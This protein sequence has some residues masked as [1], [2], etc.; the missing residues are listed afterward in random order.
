M[1]FFIAIIAILPAIYAVL[2]QSRQLDLKLRLGWL[3]GFLSALALLTV[4]AFE[5]HDFLILHFKILWHPLPKGLTPNNLSEI[6]VLLLVSF[7]ALRLRYVRLSPGRLNDFARLS[8]NLLWAAKYSELLSLI[9][10]HH[11]QLFKS[12]QNDSLVVKI[13]RQ[14]QLI[15]ANEFSDFDDYFAS[16]RPPKKPLSDKF[17][18]L[19]RMSAQVAKIESLRGPLYKLAHWFS[20]RDQRQRYVRE[21]ID[22]VFLNKSFVTALVQIRPYLGL[23]IIDEWQSNPSDKFTF[24]DM[25]LESMLRT[26]NSV[27][28]RELRDNQNMSGMHR[29]HISES[30]LLLKFFFEDATKAKELVVY[31]GIGDAAVGLLEEAPRS[32][33]GDP[34]N[35]AMG[36]FSEDMLYED[37]VYAAK[38]FFEIMVLEALHQ[39]IGWHM[40]LYYLRTMIDIMSKNYRLVDPLSSP[41]QEF[42][43]RYAYLIYECVTALRDFVLAG[44]DLPVSEKRTI[45]SHSADHE[46]NNIIKSSIFALCESMDG[47]L[48]ADNIN[49]K[50][51]SY[52]CEI[53]FKLYFDLRQSDNLDAYAEVLAD[54][55]RHAASYSVREHVYLDRLREILFE[56]SSEF[57]IKQHHYGTDLFADLSVALFDENID[58]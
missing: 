45:D 7:I 27:L 19:V 10:D 18:L 9:Q 21:V 23:S 26:R 20:I 11:S 51:R 33:L 13:T 38:H 34:Y 39:D 8:E 35:R 48:L 14:L 24:I 4:L 49:S 2:P 40:W 36:N 53:V 16:N 56:N 17:D 3:D 44:D 12:A 50:F 30:N 58:P 41:D 57:R 5:F 22:S 29:Y 54:R 15:P 43:N 52:I 32:P 25:Y 55:L 6:V 42:P 1:A 46:N 37:P 28:Y 31:K 47:I